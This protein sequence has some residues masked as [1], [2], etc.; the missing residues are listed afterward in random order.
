[1]E[2]IIETF[3][4]ESCS[5]AWLTAV[6]YLLSLEKRERYN[7]SLAIESPERMNKSDRLIV[8]TVNEF[9]V[10]REEDPILTVAGTIFPAN[11]YLRNGKDGVYETFPDDYAQLESNRG[12]GTYAMRMLVSEGK[13]GKINPLM[14]LVEKIKRLRKFN[15]SAYEIN[16]VDNDEMLEIPIY[17]GSKDYKRHIPQPCLSH[18]TFK[19]YPDNKLML[20]AVYRS[21]F[22]TT[23]ALGNF[24]GLA[25]L[26]SFVAS[27]TGLDIGPLVCHSTHA[28][29]DSGNGVKITDIRKLIAELRKL[30]N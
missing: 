5:L 2:K 25:Q 7:L 15:R 14:E 21:H 28:R 12:W 29:V 24:I 27:E 9:L 20:A 30:Q 4:E 1:M 6:E 8:D 11:H 26:Q 16:L 17:C 22:Y 10:T 3:Q 23:K 13:D 18:L 19:I